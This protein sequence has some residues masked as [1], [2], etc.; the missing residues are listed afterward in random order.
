MDLRILHRDDALI[1]IDK[2]GSL[3]SV[4]GRDPSEPNALALVQALAPE[5][6][7]VHRLDRETSGV[8]VFALG[9]ASLRALGQAFETR[10]VEKKYLALGQGRLERAASCELPLTPWTLGR[11]R[12]AEA[13]E[14]GAL[15]ASTELVPLDRFAEATFIE[16]RPRTGRTHQLRVH[17]AALGHPLL[18]DER[19]SRKEPLFARDL[20]P[21]AAQ[22][23]ELVLARTPLHAASLRFPHPAGGFLALE[24]ATPPDIARCLEILQA[25]R[26]R[27][28]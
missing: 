9:K 1:A 16:C 17:L 27:E 18:F 8:L 26:R 20:D 19:Y 3:L 24:S 2:P 5:A 13:G 22:P 4:P 7:T 11:V 6:L 28:G 23:D 21:R 25:R 10:K 15:P 14:P 12:I